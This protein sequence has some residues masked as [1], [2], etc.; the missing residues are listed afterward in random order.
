MQQMMGGAAPVEG[1]EPMK[2]APVEAPAAEEAAE[3]ASVD[4]PSDED[5]ATCNVQSIPR[6]AEAAEGASPE[7]QEKIANALMQQ[8]MGGA[9]PVEGAEPMKAAPVEAPAA[10]EAAEDASV[11]EPS[12]E[13][14]ATC[15]VQSIPRDVKI[16]ELTRLLGVFAKY[17]NKRFPVKPEQVYIDKV[18]MAIRGCSSVV[19]AR[20]QAAIDAGVAPIFYEVASGP[21]GQDRETCL[22]MVQCI[23]GICGKNDE[24]TAAFAAAGI[25]APLEAIVAKHKDSNSKDMEKCLALFKA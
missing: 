12:D 23:L 25:A 22:R 20:Q 13:D 19:K 18:I 17:P 9:A 7:E 2:A 15:N 4:E 24:A 6:A 8:M 10:E 5:K 11:D 1:A 21:H 14:K 16:D 3:D